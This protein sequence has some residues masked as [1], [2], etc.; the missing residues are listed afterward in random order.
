M[1]HEATDNR[2]AVI[3]GRPGSMLDPM[4][5]LG[6]VVVLVVRAVRT[7][8]V[9]SIQAALELSSFGSSCF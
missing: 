9:G 2:I 8:V 3:T 7:F 4:I 1:L 5:L 6:F